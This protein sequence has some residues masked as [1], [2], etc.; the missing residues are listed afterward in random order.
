MLDASASVCSSLAHIPALGRAAPRGREPCFVDLCQDSGRVSALSA[1]R[2]APA[3]HQ[4]SKLNDPWGM[5]SL[6]S[7]AHL[8][9]ACTYSAFAGIGP[10]WPILCLSRQLVHRGQDARCASMS[11]FAARQSPLAHP[12][13]CVESTR[14]AMYEVLATGE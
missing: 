7:K 1:Q 3:Y 5:S 4:G 11:K 8:R 12:F 6:S 9:V 13:R 10:S 2:K 14:R